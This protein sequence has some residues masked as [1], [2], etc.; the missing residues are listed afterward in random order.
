MSFDFETGDFSGAI[1]NCSDLFGQALEI[2]RLIVGRGHHRWSSATRGRQMRPD[3]AN[4]H[5]R[6]RPDSI[7]S[8]LRQDHNSREMKGLRD[9]PP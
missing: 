6:A 9:R 2:L 3:P 7:G 1:V 8:A 4:G 5:A